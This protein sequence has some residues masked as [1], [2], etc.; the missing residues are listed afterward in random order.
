MG[1]LVVLENLLNNAKPV[2]KTET[3]K[4]D[5]KQQPGDKEHVSAETLE[6]QADEARRKFVE[7]KINYE[8]GFFK[9]RFGGAK[10]RAA[11]EEARRELTTAL[12]R[13]F[14]DKRLIVLRQLT[15]N[16]L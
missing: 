16:S 8:E 2:D 9:N 13:L 6:K 7:A 15:E 10:R 3:A 5:K 12:Q 14:I 1:Q 4:D 11:M